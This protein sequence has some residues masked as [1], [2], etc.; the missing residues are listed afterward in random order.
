L[1]IWL[2]QSTNNTVEGN[3]IYESSNTGIALRTHSNNNTVNQNTID[4]SAIAV[5]LHSW[6]D[7]NIVSNNIITAGRYSG[8]YLTNSSSNSVFGNQIR[9]NLYSVPALCLTDNSTLNSFYENTVKNN[10]LGARIQYSSN[11]IFRHNSFMNNSKQVEIL[12]STNIWDNGSEGN[13]WSDYN[14]TDANHDGIGD[15]PYIMDTNNTD[16]YPLMNPP[17]AHGTI[18]IRADG[19]V[20]PQTPSIQ[21]DGDTY[22]LTA[23]ISFPIGDGIVVEK[24][25]IVLDGAEHTIEG[26]HD[27]ARWMS[28]FGITLSGRNNVTIENFKIR[29]FSIGILLKNS[30]NN[31]IQNNDIANMTGG[32]ASVDSGIAVGDYSN[33]N[34]VRENTLTNNPQGIYLWYSF[35]NEILE[36]H[37]ENNLFRGI[38][39]ENSKDNLIYHN[40]FEGNGVIMSYYNAFAKN[41]TEIWDNGYP[42]GGNFWDMFSAPD[43]NGDGIGDTPYQIDS[44][45]TDHYPL[46]TPF[47]TSIII[48]TDG[49]VFP[50]TAPIQ[51]NGDTYTLT[52]DVTLSIEQA[53]NESMSYLSMIVARDNVVFDGASHVLQGPELIP[54][55]TDPSTSCMFL[56]GR[57][58]VTIKNVKIKSFSGGVILGG[59]SN[60]RIMNN[61]ISDCIQ[62]AYSAG[63]DIYHGSGNVIIGNMIERCSDAFRFVNCTSNFVLDNKIISSIA[64][65]GLAYSGGNLLYHNS[66]YSTGVWI[67]EGYANQWYYGG[68]PEGNYWRTYTGLDM[69]GDGIGEDPY[70]IDLPSENTDPYPLVAPYNS[71]DAGTFN[72]VQYNVGVS[73]TGSISSFKFDPSTCSITF[74]MYNQP[75]EASAHAENLPTSAQAGPL[76]FCRVTIP[77]PLLWATGAQWQVLVGSSP[78]PVKLVENE[79]LTCLCFN[80]TLGTQTV[81]VIGTNAIPEFPSILILP[82]FMLA[83][84]M[85]LVICKRKR[86]DFPRE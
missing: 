13:Y 77:K 40:N 14:G 37:I 57:S 86:S 64:A 76:A 22:T 42:E 60:N 17:S 32:T 44:N 9:D 51:R 30:T 48:R 1:G 53:V 25:N 41:S 73:S 68:I 82:A 35:E 62:K 29:L 5:N 65:I 12:S 59:S 58:N 28:D 79:N 33:H 55:S 34:V 36:N 8:I 83:T 70:I 74:N 69:D 23:D 16:H 11:N 18:H 54:G 21:R 71:F 26:S 43:D 27:P 39:T 38:E 80:V 84:L 3:T 56:K 78:A 72:G 49:S 20:D 52:S 2:E 50:S 31:V 61:N 7:Q 66:F 15:T 45:N 63:I 81:Q 67:N 46:V 85:A 10:S 4:H 19:S 6:S 47:G 24:D 75:P